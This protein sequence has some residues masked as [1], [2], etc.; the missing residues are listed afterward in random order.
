MSR[1]R[2]GT[3]EASTL[4]GRPVYRGRLRLA[5]GTKSERFDLPAEMSE[6]QARKY[7]AGLQAEEDTSHPV[8]NAKQER[9]RELAAKQKQPHARETCDA[10]FDR[11]LPT[12]E[13]GENHRRI[14]GISWAKWIS[15]VIG[16]KPIADLTRD[17]V[18]DVRDKLDRALDAKQIRHSTARNV[19]GTLTGALK[20]A[21]AAK[22]RSLRVHAAPLH[23]GVLPPKKGDSRERPWLYPREWAGVV[24]SAAVPIEWRQTYAIALYTGLRPGELQ[25]LT[26]ADVDL[27]A[28][29][30]TV[31]KSVER[32]SGLKGP[33]T[34]EGR[35]VLPIHESLL[36]LLTA[37]EGEPHEH[38]A[39]LLSALK[40]GSDR[41]AM[42]FRAHLKAAGID[43]PRLEADNETEEPVDFRS[44]RDSY[45]TWSA[46]AGVGDRV[47]QRR[48]G[49]ASPVTTDRYIKAAEAFDVAAIGAPFPPLPTALHVRVWP[50]DWT[51][52]SKTPGFRRGILVARAGFEPT[53]FGL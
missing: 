49:H 27:S 18:E 39:P 30:L 29:T 52:K 5:D 38:V 37:I 20:A 32:V 23:F 12:K 9:A 11:Y 50:N 22:D 25:A 4:N 41:V 43:R 45:A 6:K 15:P 46:L 26:W 2:V 47:L 35:R 33:K 1:P 19:W 14:T 7:L 31:S 42:T 51:R 34:R 21:Y 16:P 40:R 53:T 48:M 24:A 13:C 44:L 36:P 17:D 10:W 8:F 28:R 3:F